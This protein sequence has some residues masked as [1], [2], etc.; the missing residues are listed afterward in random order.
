MTII[1]PFYFLSH[2]WTSYHTFIYESKIYVYNLSLKLSQSYCK[3]ISKS[4]IGEL[5]HLSKNGNSSAMVITL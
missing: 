5:P 3:F 2:R 1:I 4:S